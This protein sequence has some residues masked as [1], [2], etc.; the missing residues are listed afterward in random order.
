MQWMKEN[1]GGSRR[2]PYEEQEQGKLGRRG[3]SR[4]Q[5]QVY[6]SMELAEELWPP[7]LVHL[8]KRQSEQLGKRS[9][10]LPKLL[11]LEYRAKTWLDKG[12]S[13]KD[14]EPKG[15]KEGSVELKENP[16]EEISAQGTGQVP[17]DY[18]PKKVILTAGKKE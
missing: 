11:Q 4:G 9:E 10:K 7:R 18:N 14:V 17:A 8:E 12:P 3:N 16:V 13:N 2:L 15:I 1:A 5:T 6:R